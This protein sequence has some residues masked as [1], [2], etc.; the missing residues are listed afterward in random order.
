MNK[1][2]SRKK[3]LPIPPPSYAPLPRRRS[4]LS[5]NAIPLRSNSNRSSGAAPD[6]LQSTGGRHFQAPRTRLSM[7]SEDEEGDDAFLTADADSSESN[8]TPTDSETDSE[9]DQINSRIDNRARLNQNRISNG[10]GL[11]KYVVVDI[12]NELPM[13]VSRIL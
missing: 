8:E 11:N 5:A 10:N 4:C 6:L 2:S 12:E 1:P 7:F 3:S 13:Q 9:T